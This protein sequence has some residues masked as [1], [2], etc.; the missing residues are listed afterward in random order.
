MIRLILLLAGALL[1]ATGLFG[2]YFQGIFWGKH[3]EAIY[4]AT[5]VEVGLSFVLAPLAL[6]LGSASSAIAILDPAFRSGRSQRSRFQF[7]AFS[8]L[9]SILCIGCAFLG[10][11]AAWQIR[12]GMISAAGK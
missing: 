8:L 3:F 10:G 6:F 11:R 1:S 4:A 9:I 2:I 5:P 7:L 12:Q